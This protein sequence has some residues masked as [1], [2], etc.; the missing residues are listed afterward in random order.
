MDSGDAAAAPRPSAA[1]GITSAGHDLVG[2]MRTAM[3]AF[4]IAES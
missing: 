2:L 3:T 4:G 1:S